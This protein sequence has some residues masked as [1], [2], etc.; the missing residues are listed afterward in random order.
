MIIFTHEIKKNSNK[1]IMIEI[2]VQMMILNQDKT[3]GHLKL[4]TKQLTKPSD[5]LHVQAYPKVCFYTFHNVI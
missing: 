1:L 2:N 3:K 5:M 4:S